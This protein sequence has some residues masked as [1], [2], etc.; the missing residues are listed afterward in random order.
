MAQKK[1]VM[2]HLARLAPEAHL[3][4]LIGDWHTA[5]TTTT[6]ATTS[7]DTGL[8]KV[9]ISSET[10][11]VEYVL[12]A[13][14]TYTVTPLTNRNRPPPALPASQTALPLVPSVVPHTLDATFTPDPPKYGLIIRKVGVGPGAGF[15]N[16]T[17]TNCEFDHLEPTIFENCWLSNVEFTNCKF[18]NATFENVAISG[19]SF[20]NCTFEC[21]WYN[22]EGSEQLKTEGEHYTDHYFHNIVPRAIVALEKQRKEARDANIF[23]AAPTNEHYSGLGAIEGSS[24]KENEYLQ[25][26]AVEKPELSRE[27]SSIPSSVQGFTFDH[28]P[29]AGLFVQVGRGCRY[30]KVQFIRCNFKNTTFDNCYLDGVVFRDCTFANAT[31]KEVVIKDR[32]YTNVGFDGCSWKWRVLSQSSTQPIA[33]ITYR[34]G[35]DIGMQLPKRIADQALAEDR[36]ERR[37]AELRRGLVKVPPQGVKVVRNPNEEVLET[38]FV[39][40]DVSNW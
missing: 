34:Q 2:G 20:D 39:T 36:E 15:I 18:R 19:T 21:W 32:V 26:D 37:K 30:E 13:T 14:C 11:P 35:G 6:T 31:F 29:Q 9:T 16:V 12:P 28:S 22:L 4:D 10:S 40:L 25:Y 17:F 3:I 27:A 23:G 1:A 5:A 7:R 8:G 24:T 33:G 38:E